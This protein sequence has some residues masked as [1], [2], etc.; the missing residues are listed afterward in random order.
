MP[1]IVLMVTHICI[2]LLARKETGKGE[3][4]GFAR[5]RGNTV[6]NGVQGGGNEAPPEN[7]CTMELGPAQWL[8][9]YT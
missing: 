8:A 5:G 6:G 4:M 7:L 2:L 3:D 1:P 9:R